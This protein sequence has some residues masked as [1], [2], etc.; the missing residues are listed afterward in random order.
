MSHEGVALAEAHILGSPLPCSPPLNLLC[1]APPVGC[2]FGPIPQQLQPV[3]EKLRLLLHS[4]VGQVP[5]GG[6]HQPS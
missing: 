4:L 2:F 3:Q 6:S 1:P 5:P